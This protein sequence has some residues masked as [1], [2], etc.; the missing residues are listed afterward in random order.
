MTKPLFVYASLNQTELQN[1]Y[2]K[3]TTFVFRVFS[4]PFSCRCFQ[5]FLNLVSLTCF[6]PMML[7]SFPRTCFDVIK[8]LLKKSRGNA[9][10][11]MSSSISV[12]CFFIKLHKIIHLSINEI[13]QSSFC[14][15][16]L[17][18]YSRTWASEW[19]VCSSSREAFRPRIHWDEDTNETIRHNYRY[20]LCCKSVRL[21]HKVAAE[22]SE[23]CRINIEKAV[24]WTDESIQKMR[25]SGSVC[26]FK[27]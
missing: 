3:Q 9:G 17:V 7:F 2:E 13:L 14:R 6:P 4:P 1:F 5:L 20:G 15:S 27:L 24:A 26:T 23:L 22:C 11:L 16:G 21:H 19:I 12:W 18:P 25:S 8:T 10:G